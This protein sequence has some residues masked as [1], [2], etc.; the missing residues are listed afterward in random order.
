MGKHFESSASGPSAAVDQLHSHCGRFAADD[1]Q[2]RTPRLRLGKVGKKQG[3]IYTSDV[4]GAGENAV[5]ERPW[6]PIDSRPAQA[7][8]R[9]PA[10]GASWSAARDGACLRLL[11]LK[12]H[13]DDPEER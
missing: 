5:I 1:A 9:G 11:R 12:G 8:V 2:A 10:P 4:C 3:F 7:Q 13:R 6:A